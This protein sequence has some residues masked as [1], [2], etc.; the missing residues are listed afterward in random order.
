MMIVNN[1]ATPLISQFPEQ[2]VLP[3]LWAQDGFGEPSDEMAEVTTIISIIIMIMNI[4]NSIIIIIS[5]MI[6]ILVTRQSSLENL[7]QKIFPF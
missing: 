7:L 2:L 4:I 3:F 5:I 1:T 6:L